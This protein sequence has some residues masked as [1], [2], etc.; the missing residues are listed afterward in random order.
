MKIYD[1][2]DIAYD[3]KIGRCIHE[4]QMS[5]LLFSTG[6]SHT[7]FSHNY[8]VI[9]KQ[10]QCESLRENGNENINGTKI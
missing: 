8:L 5:N 7:K 9:R 4:N 3:L 10:I 2:S 1:F 6:K